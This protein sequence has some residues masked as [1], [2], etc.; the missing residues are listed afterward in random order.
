MTVELCTDKVPTY[1]HNKHTTYENTVLQEHASIV[2]KLADT[3]TT[4]TLIESQGRLLIGMCMK[5]KAQN[6]IDTHYQEYLDKEF[7]ALSKSTTTTVNKENAAV[8]RTWIRLINEAMDYF[9]SRY[10]VD[11]SKAKVAVVDDEMPDGR[12]LADPKD[13]PVELTDDEDG[14]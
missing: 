10:K 2:T 4:D 13:L 8:T 5:G 9:I 3:N 12:I 11:G 6:F 1:V 14:I 7:E